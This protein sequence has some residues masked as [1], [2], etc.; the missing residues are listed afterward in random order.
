MTSVQAEQILASA[1]DNESMNAKRMRMGMEPISQG[2]TQ[3]INTSIEVGAPST[4]M[5]S[6][7]KTS[8][9][10]DSIS[11]PTI[12]TL[13]KTSPTPASTVTMNDSKSIHGPLTPTNI[14]NGLVSSSLTTTGATMG[15]G[16]LTTSSLYGANFTTNNF[17]GRSTPTSTTT[18]TSTITQSYQNFFN[19]NNTS[20]GMIKFITI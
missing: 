14:N 9:E 13:A 3:P 19:N 7:N 15:T 6:L 1:C 11:L 20:N 5:N 16:L 2:V 8:T 12:T 18:S 4:F 17:V 10:T